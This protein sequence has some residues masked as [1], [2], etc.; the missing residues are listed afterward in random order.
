VET[1]RRLARRGEI[2]AF[3][4]GKDW[5]FRRDALLGWTETHDLRR[6]EPHVLVVDDEK[7]VRDV[8]RRLLE[9]ESYR[10]ATA[11]DA[12]QGLDYVAQGPPDVVLLDLKMPGMNGVEFLRR[13]RK[14]HGDVPV[15]I[16]T[17]YPSSDLMRQAVQYGPI[18]LL[19]KP[20]EQRQLLR[21][22]RVA[23]KGALAGR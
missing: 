11:S 15:L 17:G 10:V 21:S 1:V 2:P 19:P 14:E 7:V 4:V 13:L 6:R 9:P 8:V 16:I 5:R 12:E 18:T 20:L 3:K 22:V 23:L